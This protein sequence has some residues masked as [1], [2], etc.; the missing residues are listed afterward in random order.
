VASAF[1]DR[2]LD[3]EDSWKILSQNQLKTRGVESLEIHEPL[4]AARA[5]S[6]TARMSRKVGESRFDAWMNSFSKPLDVD[7][8]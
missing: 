7:A 4:P 1:A 2:W 8:R 3:G 6:Q 5:E